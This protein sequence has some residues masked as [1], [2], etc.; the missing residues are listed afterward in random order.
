MP[1]SEEVLQDNQDEKITESNLV[2]VCHFV[3][4]RTVLTPLRIYDRKILGNLV[5]SSQRDT[6]KMATEISSRYSFVHFPVEGSSQNG[7]GAVECACS[8]IIRLRRGWS[9]LYSSPPRVDAAGAVVTG[10]FG[11]S[12]GGR[13][14]GSGTPGWLVPCNIT[15]IGCPA[16]NIHSRGTCT[17]KYRR[18]GVT[19]GPFDTQ[20]VATENGQQK[21]AF[22]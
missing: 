5:R 14:T 22:T 13:H 2:G 3:I 15:T 11:T 1:T 4:P 16:S 8:S 18:Y 9:S 7:I 10:F 17:R 19:P 21:P 20:K 6:A 12:T